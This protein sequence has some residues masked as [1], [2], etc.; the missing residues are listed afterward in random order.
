MA[1]PRISENSAGCTRGIAVPSTRRHISCEFLDLRG[2]GK[3]PIR[4]M[5][6]YTTAGESTS[7]NGLKRLMPR[8]KSI[9]AAGKIKASN[10]HKT[11]LD[12]FL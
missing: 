5:A 12:L 7:T 4:S 6:Y 8:L 2:I 9:I 3:M 10:L 1:Y 11:F